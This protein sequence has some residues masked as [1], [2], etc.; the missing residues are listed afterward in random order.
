MRVSI[1]RHVK[2]ILRDAWAAN[3]QPLATIRAQQTF[4]TSIAAL[5]PH[6]RQ[7][8]QNDCAAI[9]S[10]SRGLAGPDV[11]QAHHIAS[12]TLLHSLPNPYLVQYTPHKLRHIM[13]IQIHFS[14]I[15]G[16]GVYVVLLESKL[17][18]I[19]VDLVGRGD[20]WDR[21]PSVDASRPRIHATSGEFVIGHL[22]KD[23][24]TAKRKTIAEELAAKS[25][26]NHGKKRK[27][28]PSSPD[29]A[30][31]DLLLIMDHD[32]TRNGLLGH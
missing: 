3:P 4:D 21:Y 17:R 18:D 31:S 19:V 13:A 25:Q 5:L 29:T 22:T 15:E 32:F 30:A 1:S 20:F 6:A 24:G 8:A 26:T 28:L 9:L 2:R 23:Q 11:L 16:I 27:T 7:K 14:Q 10:I 12:S